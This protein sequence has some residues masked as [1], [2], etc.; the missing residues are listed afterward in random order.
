VTLKVENGQEGG[1]AA[2][3]PILKEVV[4]A[5][6]E[7]M[8][9]SEAAARPCDHSELDAPGAR[10]EW[11]S[12]RVRFAG[13]PTGELRVMLSHELARF[14][15]ASF[16]GSDPE[17]VTSDADGQVSCELANMICGAL[18]SRL[19]P[20][21]A[22]SLNPPELVPVDFAALDGVHQC[23]DTP[24]GTLAVSMRIEPGSAP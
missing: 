9:F 19:H 24:D 23:L 11:I 8:F 14:M 7:T 4:G 22:V 17:E 15:A 13:A 6:L 20:D 3:L 16:L 5:V 21:A 1:A 12:A 10:E 2:V 18:L